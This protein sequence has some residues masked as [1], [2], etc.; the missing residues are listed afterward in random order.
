MWGVKYKV[1]KV[2]GISLEQ[3][4]TG[5]KEK[6]QRWDLYELFNFW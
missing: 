5:K 2:N 6:P 1:I 3:L 4:R